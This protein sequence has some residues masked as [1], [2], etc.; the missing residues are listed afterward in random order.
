LLLGLA[1]ASNATVFAPQPANALTKRIANVSIQNMTSGPIVAGFSHKYSN[2]YKDSGEGLINP[3]SVKKVGTAKYHTGFGTTGKDWWIVSFVD[4]KGCTYTSSPRNGRAFIDGLEKGVKDAGLSIIP[5]GAKTATAGFFMPEPTSKAVLIGVGALT[6]GLGAA[7]YGLSNEES[8]RGFKQHIL[9]SE[10]KA[11][12]IMVN[13]KQ[14]TFISPSGVST[15]GMKLEGC[16]T[17]K[18]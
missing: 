8:T 2:V 9:R 13:E 4:N 6:T 7:M 18:K 3:F 10:D 5:I 15:T 12:M 14:A 17:T 1:L 11:L 16:V